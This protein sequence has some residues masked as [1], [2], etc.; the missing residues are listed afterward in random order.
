MPVPD[1]VKQSL[2][3][4]FD[5]DFST[6]N[7]L[8]FRWIRGNTDEHVDRGTADFDDT[9]LVYLTDGEGQFKIDDEIYPI[10]AG[11]GFSF[12]EG[13]RHSVVN[14]NGTDRLLLGPMSETGSQVGVGITEISADGSTDT[15]YIRQVVD[16]NQFEYKINEGD[17]TV[18]TFPVKFFNTS[19]DRSNNILKI[20]FTT[21]LNL[22]STGDYISV[23][24]DGLQFGST[25]LETNQSPR[26]ITISGVTDYPGLIQNGFGDEESGESGNSYIYVVNIQIT[27][28]GSTLQDFGGW[29]GQAYFARGGINCRIVNCGSGGEISS[30]SGGI[31]GDRAAYGGGSLALDGCLTSGTIL[32]GGGGIAGTNAGKG[33]GTV[34][35]TACISLGNISAFGAGGIVGGSSYPGVSISNCYHSGTIAINGAGGIVGAAGQA[36]VA[37]CYSTGSIGSG[38]SGGIFGEDANGTATNCYST[39]TIAFG[40]GGIF[41][42]NYGSSTALNCYTSGSS[43]GGSDGIYA[44]SAS[45]GD[46]NFS[47][48][49][50]EN[51]GSWNTINASVLTGRGTPVGSVWTNY[52]VNTPF[53]LTNTI[54]TPYSLDVISLPAYSVV[55]QVNQGVISGESGPGI[56]SPPG[57]L[58]LSILQISPVDPGTITIDN[59]TGIISTTTSTPPNTY[60]VY[61]LSSFAGVLIFVTS[62]LLVVSPVGGGGSS[63]SSTIPVGYKRLTYS[64]LESLTFGNRLVLERLVDPN[65]RFN[66][67]ADY[68]KYRIARATIN[69]K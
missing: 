2:L 67:Y 38:G 57:L 8:P 13:S 25:S 30:G 58:T 36:T 48:A 5:L 10:V 69:T 14:T 53:I 61:I 49:N 47:E 7:E 42:G 52:Q 27:N 22:S 50:D 44:G 31:V 63:F 60:T 16:P 41:G 26:I 11:S 65:V 43:S 37:N 29:I 68:M 54:Y 21:D 64:Q 24:S 39:G 56:V 18:F 45:D 35:I 59:S 62:I 9:F 23:G 34:T 1:T 33:D 51:G 28:S 66:S 3:Q 19:V 20:I 32:S 6:V 17:W 40:S 12:S 46:T 15:I 55:R 4:A